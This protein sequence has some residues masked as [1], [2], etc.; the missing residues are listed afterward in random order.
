[1]AID[2][3]ARG[4]IVFS[5]TPMS[6]SPPTAFFFLLDKNWKACSKPPTLGITAIVIVLFFQSTSLANYL[7]S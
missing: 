1:M 2:S 6:V 5:L 7:S 4:A 3:I